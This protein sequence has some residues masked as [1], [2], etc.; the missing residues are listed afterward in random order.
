MGDAGFIRRGRRYVRIRKSSLLKTDVQTVVNTA[1]PP[2]QVP[3]GVN[4]MRLDARQWAVALA[5]VCA[6]AFAVPRWWKHA[7]RFDTGPDYRIPYALSSDY[8]LYQRRLERIS[9][10]GAIPVLGDSVVWGEYVRPDGTLTHFLNQENGSATRFVNCGVNGVFPLAMEG[11]IASY[12]APLHHRKVIVQYNLLWMSSPKADLSID[13][14][15]TFNHATLVPQLFTWAPLGRNQTARLPRLVSSIP[16][17]RA[18]AATR[19]N[20]I[21][22]RSVDLFGWVNHI[23]TV[24]Y[25][26]RSIPQWTLQQDDNDPPRAPNAWRNP[27]AQIRWFVPGEPADDPQRGPSSPRHRAWNHSGAA[28]THFDWVGLDQS[29]QWRSFQRSLQLLRARGD[30]VFVIVAP[31]N[32]AMVA[33]DQRATYVGLRSGVDS[34][35]AAR[36]FPHIAPA[37]LPSGLY[38]DASHPLTQGYA[39]LAKRISEDPGFRQWLA[40]K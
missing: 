1:A 36:G 9:D 6:I 10:P 18:D 37:T 14:E 31:F 3:F 30:D 39:L 26:G 11:L 32:E 35:L 29:L 7:E 16:C 8:W 22:T 17:Y 34:W 2:D 12:S 15:E 21:V 13:E 4:E 24:D 38:A 33:E 27:L 5:I 19:L 25:N 40:S 23:D 28:P 20:A